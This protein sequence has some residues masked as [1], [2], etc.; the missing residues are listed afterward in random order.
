MVGPKSMNNRAIAAMLICF[1]WGVSAC[2][3]S[4]TS[5]TTSTN[6][7]YDS[8]YA[9]ASRTQ[10]QTYDAKTEDKKEGDAAI[11]VMQLG[12]ETGDVYPG[13]DYYVH[14]VIDN[15][16]ERKNLEYVWAV[17]EGELTEVPESERGRLQT[18]VEKV[19][20]EATPEGM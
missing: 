2:T 10:Q 16:E 15:P 1:A 5:T 17:T 8:S 4:A 9:N 20:S 12:M 13:E 7:G 3:S 18:L 6:Q 14:A 11:T 19:Y